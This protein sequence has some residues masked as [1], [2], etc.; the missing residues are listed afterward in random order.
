MGGGR[1]A[2]RPFGTLI[3]PKRRA[4][5]RGQ[6]PLVL[7]YSSKINAVLYPQRVSLPLKNAVICP[8]R[9]VSLWETKCW[10]EIQRNAQL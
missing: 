1:G 4:R 7:L 2:Q 9:A 3:S 6:N 5:T 10:G 8:Q